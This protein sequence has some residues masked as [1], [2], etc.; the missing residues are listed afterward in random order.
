MAG[1]TAD[2]WQ[3]LFEELGLQTQLDDTGLARLSAEQIKQITG[4]EPRLMTKFDTRESR[5]AQLMGTTILPL[6]NGTY[7]LLKGDGYGDVPDATHVKQWSIRSGGRPLLTLPWR[8]G[9]S[10]ESQALDMAAATGL[11]EDFFGESE[12]RLT[13]RGRL[14]AP[15]FEFQF[16]GEHREIPLVADGVQVEVDSG[17]EGEAIHLIE[18]KL[19]TRSNFHIRQLYYP[20]RMWNLV[21]PSKRV[22]TVFLSWSNRRFSLR[23]FAFEPIGNYH[24]L[25]P[26]SSVDY[27]L[28]EPRA[29]PTLAEVLDS[30]NLKQ[31]PPGLPF[32][33]ADDVRRV[34]DV[35]DAV[36]AG[37]NSRT[38]IAAR[39]GFD[40]RQSDYYANAG[41]FLD[42]L[43]RTGATFTLSL[44]GQEFV[45]ADLTGRH[46]LLL[47]Q[48]A[49]S[50][51]FREC[52]AEVATARRYPTRVE[53]AELISRTTGLTGATPVRRATTVLSWLRWAVEI[54]ESPISHPDG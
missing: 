27:V 51:V 44:V 31:L 37:C 4:R 18:A 1:L 25:V 46:R 23:G 10:S 5:P 34:I 26:T 43:V 12:A 20:M 45:G 28:D 9:P 42:L 2:G 36:A 11:L 35:V 14:R 15:R 40:E 6:T 41:A 33:Q 3:R 21:V 7:A 24:A 30:T 32:P 22:T 19:G 8:V 49:T 16:R 47:R 54:T 53:V 50:P 17:F 13:V 39:Y 52:M 29:I 38:T 48:M